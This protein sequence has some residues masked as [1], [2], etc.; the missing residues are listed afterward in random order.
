MDG[1]SNPLSRIVI[2]YYFDSGK[3]LVFGEI[4]K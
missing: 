3:H 1:K 2:F 4:T